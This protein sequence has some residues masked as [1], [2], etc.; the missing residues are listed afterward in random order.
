[1]IVGVDLYWFCL[2]SVNVEFMCIGCVYVYV[3]GLSIGVIVIEVFALTIVRAIV[4]RI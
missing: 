1:M 2:L 3:S 4:S